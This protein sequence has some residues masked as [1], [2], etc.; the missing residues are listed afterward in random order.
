VDLADAT[1][2]TS[3][4]IN[5]TLRDLRRDKLVD[6]RSKLLTIQNWQGLVEA[7]EFNS[8]YLQLDSRLAA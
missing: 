1:G 5:R 6:L 4:H 8:T 3:V 2:L 7:A